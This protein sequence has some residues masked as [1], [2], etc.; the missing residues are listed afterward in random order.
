MNK[1]KKEL[2]E[3]NKISQNVIISGL[4][5]LGSSEAEIASNDTKEVDRPFMALN[6]SRDDVIS[7][8]RIKTSYEKANLIQIEFRSSSDRMKALRESTKLRNNPDFQNVYI[9][10]D[11]TRSEMLLDKE[12]RVERSKRN[13]TLEEQDEEGRPLGSDNG[14]K[15]YW[16]IRFDELRRIFV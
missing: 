5:K 10:R 7:Q 4:K 3:S 2:A 16:G 13:A 12:L 14:K 6:I 11:K 1:V 8:K 9:N 15:F